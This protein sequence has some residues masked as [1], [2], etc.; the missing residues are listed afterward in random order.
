MHL[1]GFNAMK[2]RILHL[3]W[4]NPFQKYDSWTDYTGSRSSSTSG[5]GLTTS[6]MWVNSMFLQQ[7]NPIKNVASHSRKRDVSSLF[8]TGDNAG[9]AVSSCD[10]SNNSGI[11]ICSKESKGLSPRLSRTVAVCALEDNKGTHQFSKESKRLN[12]WV[13]ILDQEYTGD[14]QTLPRAT[15]SSIAMGQESKNTVWYTERIFLVA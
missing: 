8:S 10:L 1:T 2:C 5:S 13:Q 14:S 7:R 15:D 11:I 3:G 9:V 12:C 4:D 6:W